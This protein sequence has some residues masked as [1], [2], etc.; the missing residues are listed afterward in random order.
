MYTMLT[1][2]VPVR[3]GVAVLIPTGQRCIR[4]VVVGSVL[5][6]VCPQGALRAPFLHGVCLTLFQSWPVG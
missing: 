4:L 5:A 6:V 2:A 1:L 3:L